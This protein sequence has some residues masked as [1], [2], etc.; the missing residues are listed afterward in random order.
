MNNLLPF[1]ELDLKFQKFI[2]EP[3]DDKTKLAID[4]EIKCFTLQLIEMGLLDNLGKNFKIKVI[5]NE[6]MDGFLI[7]P[8]NLFTAII[9]FGDYVPYPMVSN[10]Y[11]CILLN[12]DIVVYDESED[13]YLLIKKPIQ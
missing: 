7:K 9:L 6:Y 13:K 3:F 10:K 11:Y 5:K 4:Y 12:G 8:E 2:G 1:Q